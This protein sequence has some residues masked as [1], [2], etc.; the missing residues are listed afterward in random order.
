MY[1]QET[2]TEEV[3]D[4]GAE[5][6]PVEA[7]PTEAVQEDVSNDQAEAVE[8]SDDNPQGFDEDTLNWLNAKGIDP[9]SPEALSKVAKTAREAEKAMHSKANEASQLKKSMESV[10]DQAA[11]ET[12]E[13][14]M[15]VRLMVKDT[16]RDFYDSNPE[17]KE[18]DKEIAEVVTQRPYLVNDL[19]AAYALVQKNNAPVLKEQGKKEALQSLASKQRTAAPTGSAVNS[20]PSKPGISRELIAQKTAAGDIDWLTK[21]QAAI[22]QAVADGTLI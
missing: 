15:L 10:A 12:G 13:N 19:E 3:V 17:A 7:A 2:T 20:V 14:P 22:N 4:T 21:N 11:E 5:A 6:Q 16:I 18:F 8:P 9:S 1:D